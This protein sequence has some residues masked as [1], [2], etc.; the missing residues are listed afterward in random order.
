MYRF[1][2]PAIASLTLASLVLTGC[3]NESSTAQDAGEPA[4]P[5][6]MLASAPEG[7]RSVT[8]A[9]ASAAE[10]E[11]IV[12]RGRIGGR[13]VPITADSPVFTV[14]DLAIPH[15]GENPADKCRTPWDYCCETPETITT[16]SATVQIVDEDGKPIAGSPIAQGLEALGEV[17]VVGTV[18]PRPSENVLTVR[19]TGIYRVGG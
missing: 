16:N 4:A 17:I 15:C 6:W 14:M 2:I 9:K 1:T 18:A 5:T 10:G 7:A 3:G 12:L 19:A 11:R 13:K 8:E